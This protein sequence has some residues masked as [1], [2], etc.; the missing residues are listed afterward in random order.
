MLHI[1]LLILK[2]IGFLILGI[3]ALVFLLTAVILLA[4]FV[5]RLE[6]SIDNSLESA[7]GRIRFH[8]LMHLMAGEVR[9][10]DGAF[11]WHIR[12]A[13][14]K[15]G[16]ETEESVDRSDVADGS[17]KSSVPDDGAADK[18]NSSLQ[19]DTLD[20]ADG[21]TEKSVHEVEAP[22]YKPVT[23]SE[24]IPDPDTRDKTTGNTRNNTTGKPLTKS[25][26]Y[27]GKISGLHERFRKIPEKIKYTFQRIC[28]KIRTLKKKKDRLAA[29]LRNSTH[30]NAFSRLIKE[31]K[32][33]LHFLKPSDASADLE[34]GFSDPAYTGYTLAGIS[35][36]YP[37]IGEYAQIKPDFEHKVLKGNVFIKGKIRI[38]YGLVFAW[39]MFW[40]KNVRVT[41]RHIRKFRL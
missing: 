37:M 19:P 23:L 33:L 35:M 13:W 12:A 5:Y 2:I 32:R 11:D 3:L 15:Y 21:D 40:D 41:Y 30:Q 29:F 28:D 10:E 14:K 31:L 8:W 4:P 1:I 24:S 16:D 39:N 38:I 7:K 22:A 36:I 17:L 34:F 27:R 25:R 9:Y 6:F 26:T 20:D 18:E